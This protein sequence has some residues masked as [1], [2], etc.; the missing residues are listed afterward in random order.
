VYT[1]FPVRD[2]D[3]W[4]DEKQTHVYVQSIEPGSKPRNLME[5]TTLTQKAGYKLG[6]GMCFASDSRG[7]VLSL[8]TDLNTAAWQEPTYNLYLVSLDG[9]DARQLTSDGNDYAAPEFSPDGKYLVCRSSANNNYKVYNLDKLTRFDWPAMTN[10]TLLT[11]T[12]DRPVNSFKMAGNTVYMSV[13]DQGR[14]KLMQMTLA[15]GQ[16]TPIT[17]GARGC[18]NAV[19]VSNTGNNVVIVS[20]Y[21]DASAPP[22]IVHI[23]PGAK[24]HTM[25]SHANTD[26]LSKLDL[27]YPEE[28][29]TTSSRGKKIRSLLVKPAGFDPAKKYP[30]FVVMH[31]G[32]AGAWKENW[33]YRWNYHL[34]AA[35]GY[36]LVMTDYTGSTGYGEKF[37][38]DIQFDPFKGPGTEI[39]EAA[40]DVVKRFSFIDGTRQAAGGA[41]YGGHMASW[42]QATTSHYKCLVNHAGLVNSEAQ[43]GTSD[44]AWGREVMNGGAP[45]TDA[46]TWKEQNPVRMAA[47]FKTPMLLTVGE[48]DYRVP[49]NNTLEN[50][51]IHQRLK[52]PSKLVVFPDEYHWILKGENSRFF[53][54]TLHEWL[55]TYLK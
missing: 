43:W 23:N 13:E 17:S 14:D 27:P 33:G 35:P 36:V 42:M 31:G 54:K 30:L 29:W 52:I 3:H 8:T 5:Q 16:V 41:S 21:E 7:V 46:K 40:A 39:N 15:G 34:L 47:N 51:V 45:W 44:I 50:W 28:V 38:Q 55:A 4:I 1:S 48:L 10:R 6:T 12:L 20:T 9:G 11:P 24:D 2:F 49:L 26:A 19:S 53:F 37:A 25:L 32:P 22:E 18:Y